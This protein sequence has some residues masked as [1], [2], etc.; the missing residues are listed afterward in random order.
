MSKFCGNCGAK[1]DNDANVCGMCGCSFSNKKM[2]I[3]DSAVAGYISDSHLTDKTSH[4]EKEQVKNTMQMVVSFLA[5]LNVVFFPIYDVWGGLFPSDPDYNFWDVV[6]GRCEPDQWVFALTLV[7]AIPSAIML[8]FSLAKKQVLAK[9]FAWAGVAG[10][11]FL[12]VEFINQ[13]DF[14]ELFDFEDGNLCFGFWIALILFVVMVFI[15]T[16]RKRSA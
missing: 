15:P 14:S 2:E 1:M 5:V 9:I 6:S 8:I 4:A 16:K 12:I 7:I 10:Q 3:R 13:F 11:G